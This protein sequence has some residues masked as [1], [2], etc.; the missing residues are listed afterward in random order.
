MPAEGSYPTPTTSGNPP[1]VF[2][3]RAII[4]ANGDINNPAAARAMITPDDTIIAA[5]GG[6]L[7]CR[8]IGIRPDIIVGDLDSLSK[9]EVAYWQRERVEIIEHNHRKDETDLELALL[10]AQGLDHEEA[11]VLGALGSRW[12]H[13][14]AN[15]FLPAYHLLKAVKVTFWHD[16]LW[17]YLVR[18][19]RQIRGKPGQI[20]SLI[21]LAGDA[22]GVTTEGLEW[23]LQNETLV[24]GASRGVSN[25]ILG[26]TATVS[27]SDGMLLCFVTDED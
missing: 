21:P 24:F 9:N 18:K 16:G 26:T 13:T 3:M 17:V 25:I 27:L 6:A 14:F 8:A 5:N 7:H 1:E 20:V 15:I 23:S 10:L 22:Q 2:Y 12:D 4:F 19:S 11:I